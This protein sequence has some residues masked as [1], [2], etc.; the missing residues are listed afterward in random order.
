MHSQCAVSRSRGLVSAAFAKKKYGPFLCPYA[1]RCDLYLAQA[2]GKVG[3]RCVSSYF[4]RERCGG[5]DHSCKGAGS[6]SDAHLACKALLKEQ[7]GRYMVC[8]RK[9]SGCVYSENFYPTGDMYVRI[10][11]GE[12][13]LRYRY[14]AGVF[15]SDGKLLL[16]LEVLKTHK[17]GEAKVE[18][19][20]AVGVDIAEFTCEEIEGVLGSG[21]SVG[22]VRLDNL[23][24]V[25]ILCPD[26]TAAKARNAEGLAVLQQA[27]LRLALEKRDRDKVE[28]WHRVYNSERSRELGQERELLCELERA[29]DGGMCRQYEVYSREQRCLRRRLE[30]DAF[31][32]R[33]NVLGAQ[34]KR[35]MQADELSQQQHSSKKPKRSEVL[36]EENIDLLRSEASQFNEINNR[37]FTRQ[38]ILSCWLGRLKP[39]R[40]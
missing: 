12:A 30:Q 37:V 26:C 35:N 4:R 34:Q 21:A 9:C 8:L 27:E 28:E 2:S 10:E 36:Q 40:R 33:W 19:S 14:D 24:L 16:A 6:E 13:G 39:I 29:V 7:F 5:C 32:A 17:T 11:C 38:G 31:S 20:R 1:C 3:V 15:S 22:L 18:S 23:Q 25:S